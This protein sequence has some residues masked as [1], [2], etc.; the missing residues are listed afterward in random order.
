MQCEIFNAISKKHFRYSQFVKR[1]IAIEAQLYFLGFVGLLLHLLKKKDKDKRY[2]KNWRPISLDAEI[3]SKALATRVKKV[4]AS[5][6]KSDQTAYVEG[7]YIG[8]SIC[9]ISDILEYTEDQGIDGVL[10]SADFEKAFDSTEHP[11]ILTTLD[12]FGFGPPKTGKLYY[13]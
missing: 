2:I 3:A 7:R 6:I 1:I 5:I 12:S 10:F 13:E 11:F 8:E 4:V 9:L